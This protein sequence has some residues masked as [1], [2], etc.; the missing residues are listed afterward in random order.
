MKTP[1]QH[2]LRAAAAAGLAVQG[3]PIRTAATSAGIALKFEEQVVRDLPTVSS[4]DPLSL[5]G[6]SSKSLESLVEVPLSLC[7]GAYCLTYTIDNQPF[8]AVVDTGSPFLLV[9]G[10]RPDGTCGQAANAQRWGCYK[11]AAR[12]TGLPDTDELFG[13]EDVGV[14]WRRGSF[15]L[16]NATGSG[17]GLEIDDVIF[18]RINSY[19]GKGGGGAVFLGFAKRRQLR[20]RPTLLEQTG[21]ATIR[22]DFPRRTM[23]LSPVPLIS[24]QKDAL[25][26]IDL[27]PRGTPIA[28]YA[29]RVERLVVNGYSV[30][31]DRPCV[32]V[33]DTGTTGLSISDDLYDSGILPIPIREAQIALST[34]RGR[35]AV[36]EA[37]VRRRRRPYPGVPKIEA[38]LSAEEYEEFPLVVSP[39]RVPWFEPGFGEACADGE[40]FQCDGTPVGTRRSYLSTLLQ[41]IDGLGE[42]PY[43]LFVG[44]AF[45][46]P[47]QITIDIDASRMLIV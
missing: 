20:I 8:R 21:V 9:E 6:A 13:G 18:G 39:V 7:G 2:L 38:P 16:R 15:A 12:G 11:G 19:E 35:V 23:Q 17:G 24:K 43:V 33:I 26:L 30:P 10:A 45:L 29:C 32:A 42:K 36:L 14:Q 1:R 40:P 4:S 34:E 28:N 41:R 37:S 5:V 22:F 44:A 27:R 31:L 46:W 25:R 3:P 47:R